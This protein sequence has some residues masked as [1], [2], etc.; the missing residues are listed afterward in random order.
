M[1][2]SPELEVCSRHTSPGSYCHMV[3]CPSSQKMLSGFF[4]S[5]EL[6]E[7]LACARVTHEDQSLL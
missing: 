1:A 5:L 7:T 6:K 4:G 3:M 2:S